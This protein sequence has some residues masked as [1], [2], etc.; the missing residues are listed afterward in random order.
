HGR[1]GVRAASNIAARALPR[2]PPG[3]A[4]LCQRSG[5]CARG[6]ALGVGLP[7]AFGLREAIGDQQEHSGVVAHAAVAALDGDA[8]ALRA[9]VLDAALPCDDAVAAAVD[10][11]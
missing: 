4:A 10:R 7:G 11:R 2:R 5:G 6:A 9:V 8:L 3:R 1:T